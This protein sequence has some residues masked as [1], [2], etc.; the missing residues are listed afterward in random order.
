MGKLGKAIV[1]AAIAGAGYVAYKTYKQKYDQFN[2]DLNDALD[3]MDDDGIV[4]ADADTDDEITVEIIVDE[5][6][7]AES[8]FN[9][10]PLEDEPTT[11]TE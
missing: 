8:D 6:A 11:E 3:S 2:D 10:I 4:S 5:A 9:S 1:V 7:P